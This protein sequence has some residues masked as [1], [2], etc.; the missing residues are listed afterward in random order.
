MYQNNNSGGRSQYGND[1]GY[2]G[3]NRNG[4]G[5]NGGNRNGGGYSGGNRNG[6]GY[7][8]GNR[9][10]GSYSGGNRGGSENN[11]TNSAN[12]NTD[13]KKAFRPYEALTEENYVILAENSID[14]L[15]KNGN[16]PVLTTSKIRN[17]LAL[18]AEI[19][20]D[21]MNERDE[22]LSEE[23][24]GRINY[25]KVRIIYEAGRDEKVR[26]FVRESYL[27]EYINQI[28]GNRSQYLLFSRY[29]EALVA[30]RKFKFINDKDV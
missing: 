19:Y 6:G 18:N 27:L 3:G 11:K 30:F 25:L 8:G 14:A 29:L 7:S 16:P 9:N 20:N 17:I 12:S 4:G 28:Q 21:V 23:F 15:N 2:G 10:G 5:Y 24:K 13:D 22:E 1:G 26:C